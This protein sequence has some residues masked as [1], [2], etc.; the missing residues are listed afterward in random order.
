MMIFKFFSVM[1]IHRTNRLTSFESVQNVS[2][3]NYVYQRQ[4]HLVIQTAFGNYWN[5]LRKQIFMHTV[6]RTMSG[7]KINW[8]PAMN[9]AVNMIPG[10]R[11]Y[12]SM[13]ILF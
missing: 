5:V 11:F 1:T 10:N 4:R 7:R 13:I 9:Y 2:A 6:T 3:E 8:N 12:M